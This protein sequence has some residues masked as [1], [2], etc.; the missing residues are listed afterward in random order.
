MPGS[1][2]V[3]AP[4]GSGS[5]T[6]PVPNLLT[7]QLRLM[8]EHFPDECAY[9]E[10]G[11]DRRITFRQWDQESDRLALAL[12]DAGVAKGDRVAIFLLGEEALEWIAAYAAIHKAG[13]VAVPTNTRLAP[14]E[15]E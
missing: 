12:L 11:A 2:S 15:V 7:D 14:R 1:A 3:A 13:A 10:L 9:V 8:S 5:R 4:P 6:H